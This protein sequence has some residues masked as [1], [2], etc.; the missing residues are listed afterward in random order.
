MLA[1]PVRPGQ[2]KQACRSATSVPCIRAVREELD[3][4]VEINVALRAVL[5][6]E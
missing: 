4:L 6:L 2:G 1:H 5:D 3:G